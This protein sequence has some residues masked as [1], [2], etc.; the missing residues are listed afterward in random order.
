[1]KG[2]RGGE[3]MCTAPG[4]WPGAELP[5]G[6]MFRV[7][8]TRL[9]GGFVAVGGGAWG[10]A[11]TRALSSLKRVCKEEEEEEGRRTRNKEIWC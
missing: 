1:M 10:G 2:V 7:S 9:D 5:A 6:G 4:A 8:G 3:A 11:W